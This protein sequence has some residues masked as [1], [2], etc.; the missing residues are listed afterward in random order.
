MLKVWP[1]ERYGMCPWNIRSSR[2][3][4]KCGTQP[5]EGTSW[6]AGGGCPQ[7]Q[8]GNP[9]PRMR[10]SCDLV[11][12]FSKKW[13]RT[14]AQY[15]RKSH[16]G[17]ADLKGRLAGGGWWLEACW[18]GGTSLWASKRVAL[19]RIG[20]PSK[21][22]QIPEES[23]ESKVSAGNSTRSRVS[24]PNV[25]KN[26]TLKESSR[27]SL[28]SIEQSLMASPNCRLVGEKMAQPRVWASSGFYRRGRVR[29]LVQVQ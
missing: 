25:R 19:S 3:R 13:E 24:A 16:R 9:V 11:L 10:A 22:A 21:A 7:S 18:G 5:P 14:I 29:K 28:M 23:W 2:E 20:G 27:K 6:P 17:R 4:E 12:G 26:A 15:A 1:E 8:V